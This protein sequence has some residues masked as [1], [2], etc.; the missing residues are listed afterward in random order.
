[1][2]GIFKQVLIW[3]WIVPLCA[4]VGFYHGFQKTK[5]FVPKYVASMIVVPNSQS[6]GM[7]SLQGGVS[8]TGL[9]NALTT[10]IGLSAQSSSSGVFDRLKLMMASPDLARRL[11]E[12]YGM[13]REVFAS[14]WDEESQSWRRPTNPD[15]SLMERAM[16]ALHQDQY[17]QPGAE[18]LARYVSSVIAFSPAKLPGAKAPGDTEFVLV[19]VTH[20]D[21]DRALELLNRIYWTADDLLRSH[22]KE[23]VRSKIRYLEARIRNSATSDLRN[24]LTASLIR[25]LNSEHLLEGEL[26]YAAEVL[27]PAFVSDLKTAPVLTKTI[28]VP[29]FFAAAVGFVLVLLISVFRAESRSRQA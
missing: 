22:E 20:V 1:L 9:R 7:E 18:A 15:P 25:E 16:S 29:T 10:A 3:S 21:R 19:E 17:L 23:K 8:G 24:F 12:E 26:P 14:K 28:G 6:G 11:D 13:V 5:A 2:R 4:A 27:Q